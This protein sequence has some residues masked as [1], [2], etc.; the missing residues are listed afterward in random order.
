[1]RLI[2]ADRPSAA[3]PGSLLL[4]PHSHRGFLPEL[5]EESHFVSSLWKEQR[6]LFHSKKYFAKVPESSLVHLIFFMKTCTILK[7]GQQAEGSSHCPRPIK[8]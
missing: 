8:I 7:R 1:M 4:A 2:H 6:K 3:M 5:R